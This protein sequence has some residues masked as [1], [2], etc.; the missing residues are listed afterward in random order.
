DLLV[1][2][3]PT[4]DLD[5]Q[6]LDLLEDMLEKF[7]GTLMIVSHDRAFLDHTVTSCICPLSN[8]KWVQTAG[9]WSDAQDQLKQLRRSE[10][11]GRTPTKKVT[12]TASNAPASP[13]AASKLTYK[14]QFRLKEL[15]AL[16]PNLTEEISKLEQELMEADLYTNDPDTFQLKSTR[17]TAAKDELDTAETDWLELEEKR[18]AIEG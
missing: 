9:G 7:A 12:C 13:A 6:T 18:E 3:E 4:N 2:D 14:D 17:L 5:M 15:D 1:L 16:I 11:S 10:S 8:G